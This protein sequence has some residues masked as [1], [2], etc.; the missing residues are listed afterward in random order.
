[1]FKNFKNE[2]T[3]GLIR[4]LGDKLPQLLEAATHVMY[5]G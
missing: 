5:V 2:Y 4:G 1:M 3:L